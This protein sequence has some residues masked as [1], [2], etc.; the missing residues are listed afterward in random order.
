MHL[1]KL[2][3]FNPVVPTAVIMEALKTTL[4]GTLFFLALKNKSIWVVAV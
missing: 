4:T 3:K 1:P 2:Y